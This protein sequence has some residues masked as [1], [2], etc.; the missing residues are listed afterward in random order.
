MGDLFG[1]FSVVSQELFSNISSDMN[2]KQLNLDAEFNLHISFLEA[3]IGVKKILLVND[4]HIEVKI[5]KGSETGLKICIKDKGNLNLKLVSDLVHDL[6]N[7]L[8]Q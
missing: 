1:R 6:L 3:L 7:D 5:P 2:T 4:E 8:L